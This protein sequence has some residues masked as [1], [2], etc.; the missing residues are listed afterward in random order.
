MQLWRSLWRLSVITVALTA[1][2]CGIDRCSLW[3]LFSDCKGLSKDKYIR[4]YRQ[5]GFYGEKKKKENNK[6][7]REQEVIY[8][9][10]KWRT[11]RCDSGNKRVIRKTSMICK[12][13]IR[14][15]QSPNKEIQ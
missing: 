13:V 14:K 15:T 11:P 2:R 10:K 12:R 9:Q 3:H 7:R 5:R 8:V 4:R 1:A 6:T